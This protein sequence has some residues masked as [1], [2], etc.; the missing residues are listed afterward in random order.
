MPAEAAEQMRAHGA[1][2]DFLD[3]LAQKSLDQHAAGLLG[4]DAARAQIEQRGLVEIADC[5]AVG[6]FDVVSVDFEFG[7]RVDDGAAADH[8]VA[9]LLARIGLLRTLADDH[10]ALKRAVSAIE[11]NAL[12]ES[13]AL[14][15]SRGVI[16]LGFGTG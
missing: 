10:A 4:R 11:R 13:R 14:P 12:D 5:R 7:L 9:A 1:V 16:Y 8:Q 15:A 6:A 3:R 2:P